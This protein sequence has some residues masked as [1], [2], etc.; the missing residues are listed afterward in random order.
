MSPRE[1]DALRNYL[2]AGVSD[3]TLSD[4]SETVA[5]ADIVQ[6][7]RLAVDGAMINFDRGVR[8]ASALHR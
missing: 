2:A 1:I 4:S 5:I 7:A 6:I 3:R 8:R